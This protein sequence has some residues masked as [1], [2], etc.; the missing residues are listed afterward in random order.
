MDV[1]E[2]YI[3]IFLLGGGEGGVQGTRAGGGCSV[4]LLKIRRR[5]GGGGKGAEWPG[6]CLQGIGGGGPN[7]PLP[8]S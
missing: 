4:I 1:S 5:P 2:F 7:G 6:G 8:S 3:F